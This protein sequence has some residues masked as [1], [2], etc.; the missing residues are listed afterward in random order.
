MMVVVVVVLQQDILDAGQVL[1]VI[2]AQSTGLL[3][4]KA[5]EREAR[6]DRWLKGRVRSVEGM[7][8]IFRLL[9][10]C[11]GAV[12]SEHRLDAVRRWSSRI[13]GRNWSVR[14]R[15]EPLFLSLV[16]R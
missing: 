4:E 12:C 1:G 6:N 13:C 14:R 11:R 9:L 2:H 15:C 16:N 8:V 7:N 5:Y 3:V 10:R